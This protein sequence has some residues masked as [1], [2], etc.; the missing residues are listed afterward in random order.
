MSLKSSLTRTLGACSAVIALAAAGA[1]TTV[2]QADAAADSPSRF[3]PGGYID[4]QV[5]GQHRRH[6]LTSFSVPSAYYVRRG[7]TEEF[8]LRTG[9]SNRMEHDTDVH[10][11][12]GKREFE[13][14]V[15]VFRGISQQSLVQIFGG[16]SGGPILMI[17]AYGRKN[18]SLVLTRNTADNL[19]TNAF[20]A[21][22]IRVRLVHDVGAHRMSVY[23][24][25]DRKWTG[26][27]ADSSYKGGYNV[28]YGLYGTFK[29]PTHTIWSDVTISNG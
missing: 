13:G 9:A 19:I 15:Q 28:K 16:G 1:V 22:K 24:N 20:N 7:N 27:D 23:I 21:G 17:K 25:G 2:Y 10:Y 8:G 26:A 4:Y 3:A 11:R 12:S 14:D 5:D 18:G 29:A 6:D